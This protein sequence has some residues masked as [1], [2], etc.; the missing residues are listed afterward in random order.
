MRLSITGFGTEQQLYTGR[1]GKQFGLYEYYDTSNG[2][3]VYK[4]KD[5]DFIL[6]WIPY[7]AWAVM[8]SY[9]NIKFA[10]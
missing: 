2:R 3:N 1:A 6:H 9:A 7:N 10:I 5:T 4:L 8:Q